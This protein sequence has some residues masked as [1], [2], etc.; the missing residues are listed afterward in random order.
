MELCPCR[1]QADSL[2]SSVMHWEAGLTEEDLL[3]GQS[4][5]EWH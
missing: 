2:D 4:P 3:M 5:W 1:V